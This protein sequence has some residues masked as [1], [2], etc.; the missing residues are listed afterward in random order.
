MAGEFQDCEV[1]AIRFRGGYLSLLDAE[2]LKSLLG[3]TPPLAGTIDRPAQRAG[4]LGYLPQQT[5]A[6]RDFPATVEEVVLS[7]F[8]NRKG[9]RLGYDILVEKPLCSTREECADL[10][11]GQ[12]YDLQFLYSYGEKVTGV[13]A[14]IIRKI[15]NYEPISPEFIH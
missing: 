3:L 12:S 2:E 9:L 10:T 13:L 1:S 8:L 14:R 11:V 7:G 6:Q 15:Y 4:R 5:P